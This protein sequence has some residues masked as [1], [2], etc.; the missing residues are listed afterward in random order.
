MNPTE[1]EVRPD[2]YGKTVAERVMHWIL[3]GTNQETGK[4][5]FIRLNKLNDLPK[6]NQIP[7]DREG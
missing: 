1:E 7:I 3:Y 6:H 4:E 5:R 2:L